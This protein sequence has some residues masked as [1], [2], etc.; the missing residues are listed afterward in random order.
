METRESQTQELRCGDVTNARFETRVQVRTRG[1]RG[2]EYKLRAMP[3]WTEHRRGHLAS[4]RVDT[5]RTQTRAWAPRCVDTGTRRPRYTN[6]KNAKIALRNGLDAGVRSA[7]AIYRG[8]EEGKGDCF[9]GGVVMLVVVVVIVTVKITGI[10]VNDY[11]NNHRS[12]ND[13]RNNRKRLPE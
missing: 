10:I 13:H 6:V 5:R 7:L 12:R 1:E 2:R 3:T 11:R 4:R 9:G 8:R